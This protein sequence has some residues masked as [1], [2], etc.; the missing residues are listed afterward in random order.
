MT[1]NPVIEKI[2]SL[3]SLEASYKK[4][5]LNDFW[6]CCLSRETS[7]L[8]RKEVL[9]GKAKFGIVGDGK[10]LPQVV[11]AKFFKRGDWR[12]GYYRDQTF[13]FALGLS[14]VEDFFAQ[15]YSDHDNDPFSG[16]RQMNSHYSSISVDEEG[17]WTNHKESFNISTDVSCTAGQMSRALGLAIASKKYREHPTLN[18]STNF[19]ENGDEVCFVTIGDA[20][21]SEG[22]FWETI[23]AACV[24]KVPM[25]IS[26][27][28][29]GYGISVPKEYQTVKG[30]ISDAL[31]G[32]RYEGVGNGLEIYR[33]KAWD[34]QGLCQ[35][36]E[37]AT[38]SCR[39]SHIPCLIHVD[40]CTQQTGHSTSGSH[41][42]YK[43]KERLAWEVEMDCIKVMSKWIIDA[44]IASQEEVDAL[45]EEAK[46]HVKE[47]KNRA[48]NAYNDP[49]KKEFGIL[50]EL[51]DGFLSSSTNHE[52]IESLYKE[53][54]K[55]IN[56]VYGE[57]VQIARRLQFLVL[58]QP[59]NTVA[60]LDAFLDKSKNLAHKR[61]HSHLYSS[62]KYAALNV[63]N[64]LPQYSDT[65]PLKNGYEIINTFFD[66][67]VEK[68]DFIYAFGEDVGFIG[69][70]N[71][72]FA[73][74]QDK[75]S[76][77]RV[78]DTGIREWTI[79]GQAI[80][81]AMRGLRPIAEIQYLDYLLYGL[82]PLADDLA[83]L[84]WRSN[85]IQQAPAIIRTR[86]HRL[87]GIW[88]AGSPM[89]MMIHALRGMYI[90]VPRNMVQA[91]GMY[92]TLLMS[93]DPAI[94]VECLNGYRLKERMPNNISEYTI[95]LGVSEILEEGNDVTLVTYGSCV[96]IAQKGIDLLKKKGISVELID[97]QTLLPFDLEHRIVD[98]L[99]KTNRVVFMD[100]DVPGGATGFMM[101]EVLEKQGGYR[102]LD[103]A[104]I[105]LTAKSHRPP[106]GSDGDYFSKPNPEDVFET[107]YKLMYESDPNRLNFEL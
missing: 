10:E 104:P 106:Y 9:T 65:S 25:A 86:G 54:K 33:A 101:Q 31:E 34:Y 26:V 29:D 87:E 66:K 82:E 3:N 91:A 99:K 47:A 35:V 36:Y 68:N 70:V 24:E 107:I 7:L 84:R 59:K 77:S 46:N 17:E 1:D 67:S 61:Y 103:S 95:P 22:V 18:N 69:D 52:E 13:M 90:C 93:D 51:F 19:S 5:V 96:R 85:G 60:A 64:I 11:M 44:G 20:S 72:G 4:E 14:S 81:M 74:L 12:S 58:D 32:M 15:L 53:F 37:T 62:S 94:V 71:Q 45:R 39:E 75:Y 49:I 42:R 55:M 98:S 57:L 23:N 50:K 100:E 48:W 78:F 63:P 30:S 56:P 2:D 43:S 16:G 102:F 8:A 41:E 105:T 73:G 40:E 88:H 76:E 79:M 92:Q 80:G 6:I 38:D 27:W 89:G 83:T 21:T 97:V 28:D